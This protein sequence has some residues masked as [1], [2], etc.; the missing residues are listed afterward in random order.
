MRYERALY[1]CQ[2]HKFVYHF[3]LS[4]SIDRKKKKSY[5][6][7]DLVINKNSNDSPEKLHCSFLL[8]YLTG[9]HEISYSKDNM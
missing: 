8:H 7:S 3:F 5:N 2:W 6:L 1:N 4:K 9:A